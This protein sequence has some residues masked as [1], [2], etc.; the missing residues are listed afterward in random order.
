MFGVDKEIIIQILV[1]LTLM[2]N[3]FS[4]IYMRKLEKNINSVK[5]ALVATTKTSSHAEG[6]LEGKAEARQ[7]H[8]EDIAKK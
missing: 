3:V 2:V 1:L 5:D 4:A 6:K 7:E 8:K